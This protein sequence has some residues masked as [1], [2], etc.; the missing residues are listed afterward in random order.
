MA[1][2]NL[3]NSVS[4]TV[5][6]SLKGWTAAFPHLEFHSTKRVVIAPFVSLIY[7]F[8]NFKLK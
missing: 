1:K 5:Q 6:E 4:T 7:L 3:F 2:Q 8:I